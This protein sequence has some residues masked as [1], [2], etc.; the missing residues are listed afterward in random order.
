VVDS[1]DGDSSSRAANTRFVSN[2]VA[3]TALSQTPY[4][5]KYLFDECYDPTY[6]Q[7]PFGLWDFQGTGSNSA[8]VGSTLHPGLYNLQAN[9]AGLSPTVHHGAFKEITFVLQTTVTTGNPGDSWCGLCVSYGVYTRSIMIKR[10]A[11]TTTFE[12]RTNDV[13]KGTFT[14]VTYVSGNYFE[15]K[16]GIDGADIVYTIKDIN[17]NTTE[18]ITDT[19]A[20]FD[21]NNSS[22]LFFQTA[23]SASQTMNLDYVSV[24][25]EA[26]LR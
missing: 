13:L 26:P 2:A 3:N 25:Y 24:L 21:I 6:N 12:A 9:R 22:K 4:T 5:Y 14:T 20:V 15:F 16:I 17:A 19:T 18:T 23:N 10:V 11:G 1:A 7:C 8:T